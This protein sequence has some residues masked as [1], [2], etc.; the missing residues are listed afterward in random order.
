MILW[1]LVTLALPSPKVS[2]NSL[3]YVDVQDAHDEN[4]N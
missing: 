1:F 2:F 4:H 3:P